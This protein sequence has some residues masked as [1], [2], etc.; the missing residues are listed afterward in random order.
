MMKKIILAFTSIVFFIF[1]CL[2]F[3]LTNKTGQKETFTTPTAAP[4]TTPI[5]SDSALTTPSVTSS[6]QATPPTA[7]PSGSSI[8][9]KPST[10]I[11][12]TPS[13]PATTP[14]DQ[15][16][17]PDTS[18]SAT[19]ATGHTTPPTTHTS[20]SKPTTAPHT[21]TP[22]PSDVLSEAKEISETLTKNDQLLAKYIKASGNGMIALVGLGELMDDVKGE[23]ETASQNTDVCLSLLAQPTAS[24]HL[25]GYKEEFKTV[26]L[27]LNTLNAKMKEAKKS[28]DIDAIESSLNS[29]LS[30]LG[31]YNK[32]LEQFLKEVG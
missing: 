5:V 2:V 28:Q 8:P 1:V 15:S 7:S 11:T 24:M 4:T 26:Q 29:I 32:L 20:P 23:A 27:N 22:I 31:D 19:P 17:T 30:E 14:A 12:A 3:F 18:P 13:A 9:S 10:D 6:A 21:P 25:S 16:I